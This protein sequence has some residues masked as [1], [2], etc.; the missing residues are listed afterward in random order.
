MKWRH[1]CLTAISLLTAISA[2]SVG[3]F[4]ANQN[5]EIDATATNF[6]LN[7][8]VDPTCLLEARKLYI[9][10]ASADGTNGPA[11]ITLADADLNFSTVNGNWSLNGD[12]L[13]IDADNFAIEGVWT[14]YSLTATIHHSTADGG[15]TF[16]CTYHVPH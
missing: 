6:R 16:T 4:A 14:D 8:G 2:L 15:K 5:W 7:D 13:R 10:R 3:A 11:Q 1:A 9:T 12:T